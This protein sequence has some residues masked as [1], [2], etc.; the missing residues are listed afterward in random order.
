MIRE[1]IIKELV[2]EGLD[3]WVPVDRV[4]DLVRETLPA[5]ND[6]FKKEVGAVIEE[7]LSQE[8]MT[9]GDIGETGFEPWATTG[10]DRTTEVLRK[11]EAAQWLPQGGACW[12]ANTPEGDRLAT[13][14]S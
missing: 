4:L 5:S 2:L 1:E 14:S 3:D 10:A 7:L 12:L 13:A 11:L 6:A 8:I 9:V